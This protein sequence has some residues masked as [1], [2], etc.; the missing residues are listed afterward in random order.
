M[1]HS[2]LRGS[3]A[4]TPVASVVIGGYEVPDHYGDVQSEYRSART[5]AVV[6]DRSPRGK[7]LV[8]GS[9]RD[10]FLH[11]MLTNTVEGLGP[12]QGNHAAITDPKGSTQADLHLYRRGDHFLI[13]TEPGLHPKVTEFLDRYLIG[14][15]VEIEDVTERYAIV[16]VQGPD[17]PGL[18]NALGADVGELAPYAST[19]AGSVD[20]TVVKRSYTGEIGYDVWVEADGAP[21]VWRSLVEAGASPAGEAAIEVLRVEAGLPKYGVDVD[22]RVVPLEGG[23]ADT[24]DFEKGC[25]IGQEVLAK[26]QNLGKPRRYLVGVAVEGED[27]IEPETEISVEGKKVGWTGSSV[28]SIALDRSIAL[29]SIRRGF[30]IPGQVVSLGDSGGG[31]IT[32]LP[33]VKGGALEEGG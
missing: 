10:R 28:K 20:A 14:D 27:P 33:F 5:A 26:M 18:M 24:V 32:P 1:P 25:F 29:A 17:S 21:G 4:D 13:E 2:P 7:L 30:E 9:D 22:G 16:G 15:D 19:P 8:R 31:V 23:M 6:V 11:G 3:V 12:D